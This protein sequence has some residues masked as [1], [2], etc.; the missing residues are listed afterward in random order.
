MCINNKHSGKF[1]LAAVQRRMGAGPDWSRNPCQ[2]VTAVI[3]P[4]ADLQ[5]MKWFRVLPDTLSLVAASEAKMN[6]L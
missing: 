4:L 5:E 6:M 3:Q 1:P 2:E